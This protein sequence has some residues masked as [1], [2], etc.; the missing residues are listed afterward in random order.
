MVIGAVVGGVVTGG[1]PAGAM[2][3]ASIG[4]GVGGLVY[5]QTEG[6]QDQNAISN[7]KTQQGVQ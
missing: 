6:K 3:G 5:S 2:A 7:I 1:T 4:A